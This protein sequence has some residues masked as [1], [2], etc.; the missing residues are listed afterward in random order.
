MSAEIPKEKEE[1]T[2]IFM[3]SDE[4]NKKSHLLH[5]FSTKSISH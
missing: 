5:K 3:K 1:D 2:E 4:K